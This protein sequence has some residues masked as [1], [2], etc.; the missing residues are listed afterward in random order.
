M[1]TIFNKILV[2]FSPSWPPWHGHR[3]GGR[4]DL[5]HPHYYGS[6]LELREWRAPRPRR[7]DVAGH[8]TP[9]HFDQTTTM[10][11]VKVLSL[12]PFFIRTTTDSSEETQL[13]WSWCSVTWCSS[14]RCM[15]SRLTMELRLAC[16]NP[17][18]QHRPRVAYRESCLCSTETPLWRAELGGM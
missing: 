12:L 15:S 16:S 18:T 6:A 11:N 9:R 1:L 17:A 14:G 2:T 10:N 7:N 8:A 13:W 5:H 3:N 4:S